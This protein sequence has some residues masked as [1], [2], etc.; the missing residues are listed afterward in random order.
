MGRANEVVVNAGGQIC[1]HLDVI[2]AVLR[3]PSHIPADAAIADQ[4]FRCL[5]SPPPSC[6]FLLDTFSDRS[7]QSRQFT[8]LVLLC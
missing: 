6:F 5:V 2:S 8:V 7:R 3:D 4:L 1:C